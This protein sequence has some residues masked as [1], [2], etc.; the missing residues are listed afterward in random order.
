MQLS[1]KKLFIVNSGTGVIQLLLTVSLIFICV[2]IFMNRLG[3]NLYGVF[4]AVAVIGNLSIFA[5]L[6]LDSTLIK[7]LSEQ[8]KTQ[9]SNYDII[10]SIFIIIAVFIPLS[11]GIYLFKEVFL[12]QVLKIPAEHLAPSIILLK[13]LLIANFFLLVGKVFTAILDSEHK[14]YLT[15]LYTFIYSALYWGGIIVVLLIGFGLEQIGLIIC[16]SALCW[17]LLVSFSATKTWGK[18]QPGNLRQNFRR[19]A[20]KQ[21]N[22]SIKIYTGSLLNFFYEPLTKIL[23]SNLFGVTDVGV[24][25]NALK[26]KN[27]LLAV[28]SKLLYPFNPLIAHEDNRLKL[29]ALMININKALYYFI[30]PIIA[31][32]IVCAKPLISLWVGKDTSPEFLPVLTASVIAL[33][34]F[35]LLFSTTVI[36]I[37]LYLRLKNHPEKEIYLQGINVIINTLVITLLYNKIGFYSVVVGNVLSI[38]IPFLMC[39]YYQKRYLQFYPFSKLRDLIKYLLIFLFIGLATALAGFL[40]HNI[41]WIN[42]IIISMFC[43]TFSLCLFYFTGL[44]R[45]FQKLKNNSFQMK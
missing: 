9:E 20:K 14:I 33:S 13:Y 35:S 7:Y 5:N 36:P 2:P 24:Y 41:T 11:I 29:R 32:L 15:N 44:F 12:L 16:I 31:L 22:Y 3:E 39:I 42:V 18:I 27:N 26:I 28:F 8:G 25:E 6:S 4:C 17:F 23:I 40:F 30:I 37:Y 19:I 45:I 10:I 34:C 43:G 38:F 1:K 21:I